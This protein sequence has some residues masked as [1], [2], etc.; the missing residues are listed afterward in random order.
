MHS[1]KTQESLKLNDKSQQIPTLTNGLLE[2]PV[3]EV[4]QPLKKKILIARG[5]GSAHKAFA[6]SPSF[7]SVAVIEAFDNKLLREE[8]D[9]FQ[10]RILGYCPSSWGNRDR[11]FQ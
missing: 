9:S 5:D 8:R 7:T 11:G 6:L 2:S 3:I 10:L 1:T 4:N